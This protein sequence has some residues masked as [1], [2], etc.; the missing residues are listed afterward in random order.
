MFETIREVLSRLETALTAQH[1]RSLTTDKDGGVICAY[2]GDEGRKCAVGHL[3]PD[4][5]YVPEMEAKSVSN[6]LTHYPLALGKVPSTAMLKV[7]QFTQVTHD[8]HVLSTPW[9]N[10]FNYIRYTYEGILDDAA[11]DGNLT[12]HYLAQ[13]N[14]NS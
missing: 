10:E 12:M 11:W 8:S 14:A 4:D 13:E 7:L 5:R 6:L 3:I 2:R 9:A 1:E